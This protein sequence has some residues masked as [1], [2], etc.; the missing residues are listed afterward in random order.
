VIVPALGVSWGVFIG[1]AV[2][3]FGFAALMTGQALA[4]TWRPWWHAIPYSAL[5][6][7]GAQFIG[8]ALFAGKLVATGWLID[9]A[10]LLA[11]ASLAYRLTLAHK[12]VAQYPWLYERA[13][14]F[15]WRQKSP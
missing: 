8:Y 14:L 13:G 1:V 12:M 9:F 10:V 6:G 2:V 15:A 11:L 4:Q 5:L 3:L 7:A